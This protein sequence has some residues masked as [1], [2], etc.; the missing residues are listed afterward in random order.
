MLSPM[1]NR[2]TWD[3]MTDE[4]LIQFAQGYLD[5]S[6]FT[7]FHI[8][9]DDQ[10]LLPE[11]F[12]SLAFEETLSEADKE[13][14]GAIWAPLEAATLLEVEGYPTFSETRLMHKEDWKLAASLI[15][16]LSLDEP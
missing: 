9:P 5:G 7:S 15:E 16:K 13:L 14:V 12:L 4:D 1:T 10:R 8:P 11:I 2:W 3:R 6:I